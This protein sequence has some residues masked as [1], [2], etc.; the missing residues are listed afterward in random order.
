MKEKDLD[1]LRSLKIG[2]ALSGGSVRGLAHIGV[3]KILTELGLSPSIVTGT[4]AGSLVGASIAAGLTWKDIQEMASSIFWPE[5][6]NGNRLERFC[7]KHLPKTF[8]EL[9]LPFAAVATILPNK[10][11]IILKTGHLAS[12][13][14]ASCA[15]RF[16]RRPVM[17][18]GQK[19]KDG[20][21]ACVLPTIAC[22]E[23]GADFVIASDVWTL[24][25][26]LKQ[27]GC[28]PTN[29]ISGK[30]YPSHYRKAL[31]NTEILIQPEI[32]IIGYLPSSMAIKRMINIGE[33]ATYKGLS[34][35]SKVL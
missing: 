22:K 20:G 3:I 12:A 28:S 5:L 10:E 15:I 25:F 17:R 6:L 7:E 27:I 31:E 19:L 35:L 23:M 4:S 14:S 34:Q 13:I 11:V 26:M 21:M 24:S 8:I 9:E 1:K 18:E 2:L 32:P 33:Q 29:S 16:L 30:I